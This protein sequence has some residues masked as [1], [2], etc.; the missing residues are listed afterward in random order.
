[1]Y[2]PPCQVMTTVTT[3]KTDSGKAE[4][5]RELYAKFQFSLSSEH[6]QKINNNRDFS[7]QSLW[8]SIGGFIGIFVGYSMFQIPGLLLQDHPSDGDSG[9]K[10]KSEIEGKQ[11][12]QRCDGS[13]FRLEENQNNFAMTRNAQKSS[14]NAQH[15]K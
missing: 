6:Y 8:S 13:K 5:Q 14:N 11:C 10:N 1:M 2:N 12:R 15:T 9:K 4:E 3:M 7:I